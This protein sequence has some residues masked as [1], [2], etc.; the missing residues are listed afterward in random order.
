M[1]RIAG[2]LLVCGIAATLFIGG[3]AQDVSLIE[4]IVG[5]W[6]AENLVGTTTAVFN[7]DATCVSTYTPFE[8]LGFTNTGTWT[9]TSDTITRTW[10]DDS[11]DVHTYSFASYNREMTLTNGG[12]STM[13][14]RQ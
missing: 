13:Y 11:T 6:E 10:S 3:C 4:P 5:T 7:R 2:L 8:G 12:V 9:S 1:K 14:T